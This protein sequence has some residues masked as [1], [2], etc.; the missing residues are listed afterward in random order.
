MAVAVAAAVAAAAAAAVEAQTTQFWLVLEV[1]CRPPP[2][3]SGIMSGQQQQH[4]VSLLLLPLA[5][6]SQEG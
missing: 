6:R 1:I 4:L 5:Y 3:F 2:V